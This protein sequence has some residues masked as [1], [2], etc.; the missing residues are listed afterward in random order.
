MVENGV[1]RHGWY[2]ADTEDFRRSG[3]GNTTLLVFPG[4]FWASL[5]GVGSLMESSE[6][7]CR[8]LHVSG[9]KNELVDISIMV[10]VSERKRIASE[11]FW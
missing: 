9:G 2:R 7:M 5:R 8:A 1:E 10:E 6:E 11:A 3:L 4:N